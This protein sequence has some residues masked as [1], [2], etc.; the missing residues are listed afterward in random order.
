V[1]SNSIISGLSGVFS[2][3][4]EH[5]NN[6]AKQ[7]NVDPRD[8]YAELGK[9][10]VVAGQEDLVVDVALFLSQ[11]NKRDDSSFVMESLL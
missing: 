4:A 3:F 5:V 8:I 2:A 9:R 11:R 7:Y 10:K 1:P 6:A